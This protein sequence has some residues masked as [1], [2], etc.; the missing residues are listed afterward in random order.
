M[1]LSSRP[2]IWIGFV[3]LAVLEIGGIGS[4]SA[5]DDPAERLNSIQLNVAAAAAS[6][7]EQFDEAAFLF[8]V[9]QVRYQIDAKVYPP[10]EKGGDAPSVLL[11][12]LRATLGGPIIDSVRNDP[13]RMKEVIRRV[14]DWTPRFDEDY[15][16]GW[17][18]DEKLPANERPAVVKGSVDSLLRP[19]RT[20]AILLSNEEYRGI[21]Q[22]VERAD[23]E[24]DQALDAWRPGEAQPP[25][26]YET[27]VLARQRRDELQLKQ[28]RLRWDLLPEIRWHHRHGWKAEDYFDDPQV[29]ELCGAIERDDLVEMK[30][31]IKAGA[32]VKAVGKDGM[33]PLLWA[34][35]DNRFERFELLLEHG[36]NPNVF[37]ESNFGIG[38]WGSKNAF[39]PLPD[40]SGLIG[41]W[42]CH[43]G[44]TVTHKA[45]ASPY[46]KYLK[47]VMAHGGNAKIVDKK[48]GE[49]PLHVTV[50]H[51]RDVFERVQLLVKHGA[52]PN[53]HSEWHK[54]HPIKEIINSGSYDCAIYLRS[55]GWSI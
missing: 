49:T 52:D 23:K 37:F 38:S 51:N 21:T 15:D 54:A 42:G 12:A 35:P 40:G 6:E 45:A 9:G 1:T 50:G 48:T 20:Q 22:Q 33:T 47:V 5:Q 3:A 44:E 18:Y 36:A 4:V 39:H 10:V 24:F 13:E 55:P 31:L 30:R 34:Y 28:Q 43:A 19:L 27:Y 16:P 2:S 11:G 7:N 14:E 25:E 32:D 17:K 53:A 46:T 29:I 8:L 41:D 26:V